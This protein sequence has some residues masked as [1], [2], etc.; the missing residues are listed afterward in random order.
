M[1]IDWYLYGYILISINCAKLLKLMNDHFIR[2]YPL[3]RLYNHQIY[4]PIK[5][6][7]TWQ[8]LNREYHFYLNTCIF[9]K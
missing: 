1:T 4:K 6:V 3:L 2:F 9:F 5:L 7:H 8:W